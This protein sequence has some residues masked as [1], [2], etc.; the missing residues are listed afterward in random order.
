MTWTGFNTLT[1]AQEQANLMRD[2]FDDTRF[3]SDEAF[4]ALD[5]TASY[6]A[7]YTYIDTAQKHLDAVEERAKTIGGFEDAIALT[8]SALDT[9]KQGLIHSANPEMRE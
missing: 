2:A 6:Q 9:F 3:A 5:A 4:T 1:A 8:R 7:C